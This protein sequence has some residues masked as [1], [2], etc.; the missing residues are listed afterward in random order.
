MEPPNVESKIGNRLESFADQLGP[1]EWSRLSSA[2]WRAAGLAENCQLHFCNQLRY[3]KSPLTS[4]RVENNHINKKQSKC[5]S[6]YWPLGISDKRETTQNWEC[7]AVGFEHEQDVAI[8][9]VKNSYKQLD[10]PE[11]LVIL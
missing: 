9:F 6:E 2:Q 11:L 7:Q 8:D 10:S 4:Y 3:A 1:S 5:R